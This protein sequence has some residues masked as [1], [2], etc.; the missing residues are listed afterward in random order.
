MAQW[1]MDW[2]GAFEN[3]AHVP[4]SAD[5]PALWAEKAAA[6]R[7]SASC[8]LDLA[9]GPGDRHRMDLF[10]PEQ[11][12]QGCFVFVH[13]GYWM[14]FDKSWWSHLAQGM[15]SHG[16]AVAIPSYTLAPEARI[17]Q[18]TQEVAQAV[19]FASGRVAGPMR[20][21][22]H[23]AGGHLVSR[24]ICAGGALS[25]DVAERIVR[26]VSISGVHDLRPLVLTRMN[27]GLRLTGAE[28]EAESPAVAGPGREVPASFWVGA[29]E[30]PEFLRQTRLISERWQEAGADG[31][32]V[33]DPGQNH[34]SVID[35]LADG[36]SALVREILS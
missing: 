27:A 8:E 22:G 36:G 18:I 9:Y 16:W 10:H 25:D 6:F 33:Y 35:A 12:V 19:T 17:S 7:G 3:G 15:L 13:G 11:D 26:V 28:A 1:D 24:M 30:R 2:D 20:L 32:D 23:S 21:A 14:K 29:G 34:F 4:G 5:L 31:R